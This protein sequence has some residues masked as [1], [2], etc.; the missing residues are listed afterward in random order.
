[1]RS[2]DKKREQKVKSGGGFWRRYG[3]HVVIG[4]ILLLLGG[5]GGL[6]WECMKLIADNERLESENERLEGELGKTRSEVVRLTNLL[7]NLRYLPPPEEIEITS[8]EEIEIASTEKI[9]ITFT[10]VPGRGAGADSR[11]ELA[12]QVDGLEE[13]GHY[14]I[15]IYSLGDRWYVQPWTMRPFTEIGDDGEWHNLVHLGRRYAALVVEPTY[16]AEAKV[17]VLPVTGGEVLAV[18][19]VEAR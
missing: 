5:I 6:S 8:T 13:P 16:E 3:T 17:E 10:K 1:V 2:L 7:E 18:A 11:E 15:V 19:E 9:E 12:G 14:K 4:I